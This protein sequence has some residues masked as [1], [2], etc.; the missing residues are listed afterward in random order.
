MAGYDVLARFYDALGDRADHAAHV[1]GLIEE[2]HPGAKTVL[3]LACG[4]GSVLKELQAHYDVTGVDLSEPM[5]EL[6]R[7]KLPGVPLFQGDMTNVQLGETFDVVLCLFD[8]VNHLLEFAQW[9]ALFDV[10]RSHLAEGGLF[11]FD[12]NTEQRLAGIAAAP[13]TPEWFGEG[14]LLLMDVVDEGDGVYLWD[15]RI[16]EHVR[17]A[18]YRLHVDEIR[19]VSFPRERIEASLR[20]RFAEVTADDAPRVHFVCRAG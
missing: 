20:K 11:V 19:E 10:A 7:E 1:R 12:I 18:E 8:S 14:N 17:D 15:V 3:E 4:T 6:A 16:F 2:H 9:E 5:L 13:A